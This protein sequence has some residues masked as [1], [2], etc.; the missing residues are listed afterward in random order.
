MIWLLVVCVLSLCSFWNQL[1]TPSTCLHFQDPFLQEQYPVLLSLPSH[2]LDIFISEIL[3][4]T[5]P[6][7]YCCL[8]N[9]P[10][11]RDLK[12]E[13]IIIPHARS[14]IQTRHRVEAHH[15]FT[16]SGASAWM[17]CTARAWNDWRL[18][19]SLS[20]PLSL[21]VLLHGLSMWLAWASPQHGN[22]RAVRFLTRWLRAS[23][24][25]KQKLPVLLKARSESSRASLPPYS[26]SQSNHKPAQIQQRGHRPHLSKRSVK[27]F[28]AI[29][30]LPHWTWQ[31]KFSL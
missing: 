28:V 18:A 7:I 26:V 12:Q 20:L 30:N 15:C 25:R 6:V 5:V 9:Y 31:Q 16:K 13:F 11:L 4:L 2:A 22:L 17:T 21:S 1:Q 23:R 19:R 27:E 3:S 8:M 29:F 10:K 24:G 14:G